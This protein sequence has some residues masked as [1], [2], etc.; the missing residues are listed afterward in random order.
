M[1]ADLADLFASVNDI[2]FQA[3]VAAVRRHHP[4]MLTFEAYLRGA[5]WG[6]RR[7]A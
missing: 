2:G 1:D 3:D 7:A 4:E 6:A 5:G